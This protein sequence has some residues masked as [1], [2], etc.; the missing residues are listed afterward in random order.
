VLIVAL[1]WSPHARAG[2]SV[3]AVR[4]AFA[5]TLARF[6]AW[7]EEALP[8]EQATAAICA[9]GRE[10]VDAARETIDGKPVDGRTAAVTAH[11]GRS[12]VKGC[13][14]L[15]SAA[16]DLSEAVRA[17]AEAHHT[18]T[19]GIGRA[20]VEDDGGMIATEIEDNRLRF[21]VNL[22]AVRAAGI[23]I[24]PRALALARDVVQ[25]GT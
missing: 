13:N 21:R 11:G 12:S 8:K 22:A 5:L 24:N 16:G 10:L 15:L 23:V 4:A 7:P 17:D 25:P 9:V 18:L 3:D 20:F 1:L 19:I 6:A 14:V 2:A